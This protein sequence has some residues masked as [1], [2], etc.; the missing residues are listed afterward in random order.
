MP[1]DAA[2]LM[3]KV[4]KH[5]AKINKGVHQDDDEIVSSSNDEETVLSPNNEEDANSIGPGNPDNLSHTEEA[6]DFRN[7][8]VQMT[9]SVVGRVRKNIFATLMFLTSF[10]L[11]TISFIINFIITKKFFYCRTFKYK[12]ILG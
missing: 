12:G 5:R 11:S 8:R 3:K 6:D 10:R 2:K 1:L 4:R 9:P 7:C